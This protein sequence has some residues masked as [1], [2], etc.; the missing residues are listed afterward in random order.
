MN[1]QSAYK[2]QHK[3]KQSEISYFDVTT[4]KL[5]LE[6]GAREI[7]RAII[8]LKRY[9]QTPIKRDFPYIGEGIIQKANELEDV[10]KRLYI[11]NGLDSADNYLKIYKEKII[12][13]QHSDTDNPVTILHSILQPITELKRDFHLLR[14]LSKGSRVFE[15]IS[16][17]SH[18]ELPFEFVREII[19]HMIDDKTIQ[20]DLFLEIDQPQDSSTLFR[21]NLKN[22]FHGILEKVKPKDDL[23]ACLVITSDIIDCFLNTCEGNKGKLQIESLC[24]EVKTEKKDTYIDHIL[25]T[26]QSFSKN[27]QDKELTKKL[28]GKEITTENLMDYINAE[29]ELKNADNRVE[30]KRKKKKKP[31][32]KYKVAEEVYSSL[33]TLNADKDIDKKLNEGHSP[34]SHLESKQVVETTVTALPERIFTQV[35]MEFQGNQNVSNVVLNDVQMDASKNV[36]LMVEDKKEL[37]SATVIPVENKIDTKKDYSDNEN[38]LI[39][40]VSMEVEMKKNL[41]LNAEPYIPKEKKVYLNIDQSAGAILNLFLSVKYNRNFP[42]KAFL[43][44]TYI[45]IKQA[46]SDRTGG[47][48][49]LLDVYENMKKQHD[50][51]GTSTNTIE[52]VKQKIIKL[53]YEYHML[54]QSD[55]DGHAISHIEGEN[56]D[57]FSGAQHHIKKPSS[58]SHFHNQAVSSQGYLNFKFN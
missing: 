1:E 18:I 25:A 4:K 48:S 28:G 16:K 34:L 31:K 55:G 23:R 44:D 3:E 19:E 12:D 7:E 33:P 51:M 50:D 11:E 52:L 6:E 10:V 40:N 17:K 41:P 32:S 42:E 14:Y 30:P 58:N 38:C 49:K 35:D 20:R 56:K 36:G 29:D 37:E 47:V 15:G 22:A 8:Y 2:K 26:C 5:T 43:N 13:L 27:T 9:L 24:K 53:A 54:Y 21:Q 57:T 39:N 45:L 46:L